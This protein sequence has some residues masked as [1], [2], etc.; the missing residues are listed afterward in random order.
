M[1]KWRSKTQ[2]ICG[3]IGTKRTTEAI[4]SQAGPQCLQAP[5]PDLPFHSCQDNVGTSHRPLVALF[6]QQSC[7]KAA[8]TS[9]IRA[10][11]FSD[12][13]HTLLQ[14]ISHQTS[15]PKP[16][17]TNTFPCSPPIFHGSPLISGGSRRLQHH[18]SWILG[19][20]RAG[21]KILPRAGRRGTS[22]RYP[23]PP[24]FHGKQ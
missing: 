23:S 6:Y 1:Y 12:D 2:S 10:F 19:P 21:S 17:H 13:L 4:I 18:R 7:S 11:E 8:P 20:Q 15:L 14:L 5:C 16:S 3:Y 9:S 22:M 24:S